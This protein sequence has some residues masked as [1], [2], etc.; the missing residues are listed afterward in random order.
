MNPT[1]VISPVTR[2]APSELIRPDAATIRILFGT[3]PMGG[4]GRCSTAEPS[5]VPD[6][7]RQALAAPDPWPP[8][9]RAPRRA[10]DTAYRR[11]EGWLGWRGE[12]LVGVSASD[13]ATVPLAL[14]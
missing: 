10:S 9:Q 3:S 12:L 13:I 11:C 7:T 5:I 2:T 8:L 1:P 4:F 6:R 14:A